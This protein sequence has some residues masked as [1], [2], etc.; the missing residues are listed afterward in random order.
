MFSCVLSCISG[1]K[2]QPR[3]GRE[4]WNFRKEG[5]SLLGQEDPPPRRS[6]RG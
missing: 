6:R 3:L 4:D 1:R 5:L 2:K